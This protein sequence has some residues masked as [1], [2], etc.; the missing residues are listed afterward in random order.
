M[1]QINNEKF[2]Q[3]LAEVRKEKQMTQKDLAD[4]LFVS[5]KQLVN[6]NVETVCQMLHYLSLLLI[7]LVLQ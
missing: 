7:Y 3:F 4:K 2:G 5:D 6:G 1:Y